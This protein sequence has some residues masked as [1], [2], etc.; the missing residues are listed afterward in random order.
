MKQYCQLASN[1][2]DGPITGLLASARG[3]VQTP[4]SQGR[5]SSMGPEDMVGAL[6]QQRPEVDRVGAGLAESG[7]MTITY[8]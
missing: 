7:T 1:G 5:I 8:T 3:Q 6:D 2:Y 4:L